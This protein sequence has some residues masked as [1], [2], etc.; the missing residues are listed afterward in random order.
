MPP[1]AKG[2]RA[3]ITTDSSLVHSSMKA[4]YR[5]LSALC[6]CGARAGVPADIR[7]GLALP[8]GR[9]AMIPCGV[10]A[11]VPL[12]AASSPSRSF[13][14]GHAARVRCETVL[15]LVPR[16]LRNTLLFDCHNV[17]LPHNNQ[18]NKRK[19]W[20][21][22]ADSLSHIANEC[23]GLS[24]QIVGQLRLVR[25]GGGR[26]SFYSRKH[27][28]LYAFRLLVRQAVSPFMFCQYTCRQPRVGMGLE[29]CSVC[30]QR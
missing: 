11:F 3:I 7:R 18:G 6:G 4:S 10:A 15:D 20:S 21:L 9:A 17:S 27:A 22:L 1:S 19:H 29:V 12:V 13:W 28:V 2:L 14:P 26:E 16:A 24:Q 30:R 5:Y 23:T 8:L 25:R